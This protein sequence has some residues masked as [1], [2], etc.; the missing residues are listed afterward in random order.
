MPEGYSSAQ[1]RLG[2]ALDE[3]LESSPWR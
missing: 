2:G 1:C 3:H